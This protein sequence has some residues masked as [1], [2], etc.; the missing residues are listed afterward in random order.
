MG[1]ALGLVRM[2]ERCDFVGVFFDEIQKFGIF[3]DRD[4]ILVDVKCRKVF[5]LAV[6]VNE[7]PGGN[8]DHVF[9]VSDGGGAGTAESK[10]NGKKGSSKQGEGNNRIDD[11][12]T[13]L[14]F[15]GF[16]DYPDGCAFLGIELVRIGND[17]LGLAAGECLEECGPRGGGSFRIGELLGQF[18]GF[19]AACWRKGAKH[20]FSDPV[21]FGLH[22]KS[23]SGLIGSDV[24]HANSVRG[25]NQQRVFREKIVFEFFPPK[26]IQRLA[27]G[28]E[29]REGGGFIERS[30]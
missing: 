20:N 29:N 25:S 30:S 7:F 9:Q 5:F 22:I 13:L 27:R 16:L 26:I 10:F 17:G 12:S 6:L 4:L 3:P 15:L 8:F 11:H 18:A 24:C 19:Q 21:H 2:F 14:A 1:F 23:L 28:L